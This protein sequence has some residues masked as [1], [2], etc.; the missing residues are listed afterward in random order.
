MLLRTALLPTAFSNIPKDE[1]A[2]GLFCAMGVSLLHDLAENCV[3]VINNTQKEGVFEGVAALH[4]AIANWPER[5]RIRAQKAITHLQKR[6]RFVALPASFKLEACSVERC[7]QTLSAVLPPEKFGLH[8]V[9]AGGEC[10]A[11]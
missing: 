3:V 8:A 9:F 6:N 11:C 10:L 2:I 7:R 1:E 5:F 4:L